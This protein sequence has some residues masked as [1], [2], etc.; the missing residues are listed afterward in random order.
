MNIRSRLI[1]HG[2][3]LVLVLFAAQMGSGPANAVDR[4]LSIGQIPLKPK[5]NQVCE[6]PN[7]LLT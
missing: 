5:T 4:L 2:L 1:R 6:T 7:K 3:C